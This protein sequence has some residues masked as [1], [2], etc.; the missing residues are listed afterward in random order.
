VFAA[1]Y[2]VLGKPLLKMYRP[3]QI[4]AYAILFGTAFT[5]PLVA[6]D[7]ARTAQDLA[8]M[9]LDG[10]LP[11]LYLGVFPTFIG[12][13]IWYRAMHTM[14]ASA[15]GTYVYLSTLVAVLGGVYFLGESLTTPLVGGGVM[16]IAGVYL[17][18]RKR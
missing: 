2:A 8:T 15:V 12:Y 4:V 6:A 10:W 16:V 17:A 13:G 14:E 1:L 3:F 11:V 5:L 9:G 18:Q 7:A